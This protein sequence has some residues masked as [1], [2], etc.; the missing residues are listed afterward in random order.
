MH[1]LA[2]VMVLGV[3][4]AGSRLMIG[5]IT[6]RCKPS[7]SAVSIM[8]VL[9]SLDYSILGN[10]RCFIKEMIEDLSD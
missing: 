1:T 10:D 4:E 2:I 6:K 8:C 5:L 3:I 7:Q 9:G